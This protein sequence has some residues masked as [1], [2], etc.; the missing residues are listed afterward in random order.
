MNCTV[1][2]A[3]VPKLYPVIAVT[4][5]CTVSVAIVPKLY[6]VIAVTMDCTKVLQ[7]LGHGLI[8]ELYFQI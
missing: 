5:N 8:D 6:P 7:Y 4:M 1:S 2:V 3:I